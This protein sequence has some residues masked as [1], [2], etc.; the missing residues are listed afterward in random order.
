MIFSKEAL[1]QQA[2]EINK[3]FFPERLKKPLALDPYDLIDALGC[4]VEWKYISPNKDIL[5]LT[6]FG[7]GHWYIWPTGKDTDG[8]KLYKEMFQKGTVVIN[9]TVLDSQKNK[10][11]ENFIVTHEAGHWIKD[12]EYF[13]KNDAESVALVCEKNDFEKTFW[14]KSMSELEVIER[15]TNYLAAAI[16]MPRA[17]LKKEFFRLARWKT[18]PDSPIE[19]KDYM[20]G[21]IGVLSKIF[22][23]NFNPVKYRL[24]DIGV[25]DFCY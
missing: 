24:K 3:K 25:L 16:L 14:N 7:D 13:E 4:S 15:Q 21:P 11:E 20:K 9:Q 19:F 8:E 22:D 6:F 5:G 1:E 2:E 17:V 12:R 18:I 23:V 10:K